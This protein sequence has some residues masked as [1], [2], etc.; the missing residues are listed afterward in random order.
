MRKDRNLKGSM[1]IECALLMPI[2]ISVI[3]SVMWLMIYM[4]DR[5]MINRA[6]IHGILYCD[7][8]RKENTIVIEKEIEKR[9]NE[10][11][12]NRILA[13][14]DIKVS[15]KFNNMHCKVSAEARMNIPGGIEWL[16]KMSVIRIEQ[17]KYILNGAAVIRDIDRAKTYLDLF[18]E[19]KNEY[20]GNSKEDI[21]N[22]IQERNE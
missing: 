10:D 13:T 14:N 1:T 15:V 12:N 11:L 7:Y 2:I 3:I 16:E 6:L 9:I 22:R 19:I 21:E 18:N 17:E 8:I 5:I 4:Y 20:G